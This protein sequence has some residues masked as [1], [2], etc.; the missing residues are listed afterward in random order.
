MNKLF[1]KIR[2]SLNKKASAG[3]SSQSDSTDSPTKY[4]HSSVE[5]KED[6]FSL[7]Q[8]E[9][10]DLTSDLRESRPKTG[11]NCKDLDE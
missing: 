9:I 7:I 6:D 8:D 5:W 4:P 11:L 3:K 2:N 1:D 10:D